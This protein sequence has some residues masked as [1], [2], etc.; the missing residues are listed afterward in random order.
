MINKYRSAHFF[1]RRPLFFIS[2]FRM[3]WRLPFIGMGIS[4][5]HWHCLHIEW[6]FL[7]ANDSKVLRSNFQ[8][9]TNRHG[10]LKWKTKFLKQLLLSIRNLHRRSNRDDRCWLNISNYQY[11]L[12]KSIISTIANNWFDHKVFHVQISKNYFPQALLFS[13]IR[14]S[15]FKSAYFT[16]CV[17]CESEHYVHAFQQLSSNPIRTLKVDSLTTKVAKQRGSK[18]Y[19][20]GS[21]SWAG[22][23]RSLP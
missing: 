17:N 2:S 6:P 14:A 18:T 4:S 20:L 23:D 22:K 8:C 7:N 1:Y 15:K 10:Q 19:S 9:F 21:L 13:K 5:I 3:L 16:V 11:R 12:F